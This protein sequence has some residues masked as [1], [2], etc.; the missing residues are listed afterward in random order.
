[1][2]DLQRRAI[3]R[4]AFIEISSV[5]DKWESLGDYGYIPIDL[6]WDGIIEVDGKKFNEFNVGINE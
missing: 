5:I 3:A 1:M 4:L 2:N 6:H